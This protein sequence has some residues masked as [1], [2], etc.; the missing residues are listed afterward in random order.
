MQRGSSARHDAVLPQISARNATA[1]AACIAHLAK[2][3][4]LMRASISP[5]ATALCAQQLNL[6][7][8]E[9]AIRATPH[10]LA[11]SSD[12]ARGEG[13]MRNQPLPLQDVQM[14]SD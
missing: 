13:D 14:V 8:L 11:R 2:C 1:R 3:F 7:K 5:V 10:C 12:A 4:L 9:P 6:L